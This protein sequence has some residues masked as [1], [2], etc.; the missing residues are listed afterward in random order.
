[1]GVFFSIFPLHLP[2]VKKKCGVCV[3][4]SVPISLPPGVKSEGGT[5]IVARGFK[6]HT[7]VSSCTCDSDDYTGYHVICVL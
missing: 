4:D 1:M 7:K 2:K 3:C 6:E 5:V